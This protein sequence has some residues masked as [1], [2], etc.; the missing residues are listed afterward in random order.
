MMTKQEQIRFLEAESRSLLGMEMECHKRRT[1]ISK[2]LNQLKDELALER[3][4]GNYGKLE[5]NNI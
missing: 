3:A 4:R 5:H 2:T 1:Q